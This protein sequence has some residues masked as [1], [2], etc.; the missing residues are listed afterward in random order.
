MTD[1]SVPA[2]G[3][4]SL[5]W[6]RL[7]ALTGFAAVISV[8][9]LAFIALLSLLIAGDLSAQ[10]IAAGFDQRL[11]RTILFTTMQAGLSALLSVSLAIPVALAFSRRLFPGRRILLQL[12]L[13]SFVFPP[14]VAV[15]GIVAVY[16]RRGWLNDLLGLADLNTGSWI[17]G[18][19]GILIA[20]VFFNLPLALLLI[21]TRLQAVPRQ[22]WQ[23]ASQLGLSPAAVLRWVDWPVIRRDLP[24][25]FFIIFLLCF[26]SFA[27]VLAMGGGPRTN[28]LEVAIYEALRFDFDVARAALLALLQVLICFGLGAVI[29]R[30]Q[31]RGGESLAAFTPARAPLPR[32]DR[33]SRPLK[34]LDGL[35]LTA[36]VLFLVP[37]L[38]AVVLEG[39]YGRGLYII[40]DA[41]TLQAVATSLK[42]AG[43]SGL[44][45]VLL[46]LAFASVR[47]FRARTADLTAAI[48]LVFPTYVLATGLFLVLRPLTG[49]QQ[50]GPVLVV[51]TN[52]L[53]ALPFALRLIAPDVA[54]IHD[55]HDRTVQMLG[56]A[57]PVRWRWLDGPLLAPNLLRAAGIAAAL[58]MGDLGV[59]A[60]F[61]SGDFQTL[62]HLVYQRMGSY[63]FADAA[64]T[65]LVLML[66]TLVIFR[67]SFLLAGWLAPGSRRRHRTGK[68]AGHAAV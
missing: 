8:A 33:A 38:L 3:R 27:L 36:F 13:L 11:L 39:A 54:M 30:S 42:V 25:V 37:P 20:H 60:L 34:L 10:T 12:S 4:F 28:S 15:L 68:A 32:P 29:L 62:P 17:F 46:A 51:L 23:T 43:L 52:A 21:L 31:V 22:S 55:R 59:I 48:M 63:R 19:D 44:L 56:L 35:V 58:S 7:T 26:T 14:I 2:S 16:G 1:V 9:G 18:L 40:T 41:K 53:V 57:G 67:A 66:L 6:P 65:A 61:S 5:T 64:T 49:F 50:A 24:P 45:A 47:L